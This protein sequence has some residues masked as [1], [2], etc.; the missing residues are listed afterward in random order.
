MNK[1]P[2]NQRT[3]AGKLAFTLI[4]LLVVIAIIA[5][6]AAM[7]F[8]ITGAVN[9]AKVKAKARVEINNV[10]TF[11]ESYKAKLGHYPPDNPNPN[12]PFINP[13]YYE[14]VG[15]KQVGSGGRV[16]FSALD[17]TATVFTPTELTTTF[18]VSGFVN[19]T[20]GSGD[21]G[22]VAM[23][24]A[25]SLAPNQVGRVPGSKLKILVSSI[26]WPANNPGPVP[27]INPVRYNSSTPR[28]NKNEYDVWID[29]IIAGKTN[30][31]SNWSKTPEVVSTPF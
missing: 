7:V 28:H 17:D 16:T 23:N 6:L 1:L 11:I 14:L 20:R 31:F 18:G 27:G 10:V 26:L 12:N 4:E 15:T 29:V 2:S 13:L 5:L 3:G 24:F 21:E 22:P 30:R 25:R 19:C 8:P 9:K